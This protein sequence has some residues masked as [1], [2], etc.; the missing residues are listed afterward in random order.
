MS[1]PKEIFQTIKDKDVKFVD[2]RFTDTRGLPDIPASLSGRTAMDWVDRNS[3]QPPGMQLLG[4]AGGAGSYHAWVGF[5]KNQRRGVVVLSTANDL[6]V[7]PIGWTILQRL[8]LKAENRTQFA[9]EILGLGFAYELDKQTQTLRVTKVFSNSPA[10]QAGLATGFVIQKIENVS[11]AGKSVA[12]CQRLLRA[13]GSPKVRLELIDPQ[14]NA[15]NIV[16]VTRGKFLTS[17]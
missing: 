4:H 2:L 5:D 17:G 9:R 13:N 16:E 15:T 14:R 7:E 8:A 1:T 12:E 6:S 10:S 11:T 3:Y